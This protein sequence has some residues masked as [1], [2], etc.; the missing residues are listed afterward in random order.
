MRALV[1]R[2]V[3]ATGAGGKLGHENARFT[4]HNL[5]TRNVACPRKQLCGLV[6]LR[7]THG[8]PPLWTYRSSFKCLPSGRH[9]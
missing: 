2:R 4:P 7:G 9:S 6:V 3:A 5:G 1:R 8:T